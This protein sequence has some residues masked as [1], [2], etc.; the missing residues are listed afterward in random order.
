VETERGDAVNCVFSLFKADRHAIA[1]LLLKVGFNTINQPNHSLYSL[2]CDRHKLNVFFK[3]ILLDIIY[4]FEK[5]ARHVSDT[6]HYLQFV[7]VMLYQVH[8]AMI[9]VNVNYVISSTPGHDRS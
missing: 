5:H 4:M 6:L 3:L 9:G 8:L 7:S 2:N 1:E